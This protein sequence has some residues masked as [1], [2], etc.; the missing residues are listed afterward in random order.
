MGCTQNYNKEIQTRNSPNALNYE[1]LKK[2]IFYMENSICKINHTKGTGTGFLCKIRF[3][4]SCHLLPVLITCNHVLD[5]NCLKNNNKIEF[6]IKDES[7]FYSLL[8]DDLRIKYTNVEKDVTIIEIKKKDGL[9]FDCFL[10]I[11]ESIYMENIPKSTYKNRPIYI[12][13][14]EYGQK[15]KHSIGKILGIF[16]DNFTIKHICATQKGSSGSPIINVE[17][18]K[19]IGVHKGS[20]NGF[21]LGSLIKDSIEE[22]N[23]KNRHNLDNID[24]EEQKLINTKELLDIQEE[25]LK[26]NYNNIIYYDESKTDLGLIVQNSD[27]FENNTNGAF[28]LTQDFSS[29]KIIIEEISLEIKKNENKHRNLIFNLII[30]KNNCETIINF[31]KDLKFIINIC[32][33]CDDLNEYT[34]LKNKYYNKINVYINKLDI[35]NFINNTSSNIIYPYPLMKPITFKEYK[36]KYRDLHLGISGFYGDLTPKLF[37][38]YFEKMNSLI[39]K[40][41][42]IEELPIDKNQ[43]LKAFLSFDLSED[44][45]SEDEKIIKEFSSEVYYSHL[46]R[47]LRKSKMKSDSTI[48]YFTARLMLS[49]NSNAIKNN[50]Y[51]NIN[52]KKYYRGKIIPYSSFLHYKRAVGKIITSLSFISTSEE[53]RIVQMFGKHRKDSQLFVMF[54]IENLS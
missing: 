14:Y 53:E 35:I 28:I 51:C 2:A 46:N 10:E 4:D 37:H 31:E 21:N 6:S 20:E 36:I 45:K 9:N 3:P 33:Y 39:E 7:Y 49:L 18:H 1:Q 44:L 22:F 26:Q 50:M 32:I 48:A 41:I 52:K 42:K 27:Y 19:V 54:I 24:K 38:Y 25:E 34:D 12:L 17:N 40:D 43:L 8:M 47:W 5:D 29:L 16:E 15:V 13:H 23:N 11:D 30:N